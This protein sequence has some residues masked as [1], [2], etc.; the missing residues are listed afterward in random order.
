M[1]VIDF[2]QDRFHKESPRDFESS[3]IEAEVKERA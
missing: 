3:L 1:R 2:M